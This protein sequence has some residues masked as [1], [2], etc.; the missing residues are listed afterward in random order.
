MNETLRHSTAP[1]AVLQITIDLKIDLDSIRP[2]DKQIE[3]HER[4]IIRLKRTRSSLLNVSTL[5]PPEILGGIFHWNVIPPDGDFGELSKNSYDFLL[6][7]HRWFEVVS[8][9][10]ELWS[11]WN[12]TV[13][14]WNQY[15]SRCGHV[16]LDLVLTKGTARI[17][18]SMTAYVTRSAEG[19][20][21]R[22]TIRRVHLKN[23]DASQRG[24]NAA[25]QGG[26]VHSTEPGVGSH[27]GTC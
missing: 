12:N 3:E 5:L 16:P 6:V 7:Y 18:I 27:R 11:F 8:H 19:R 9:T 13:Q 1:D 4:A 17:T 20:A 25:E 14:D 24:G 10:S 15:H 23:C 26:V 22:N 21:A 2:L